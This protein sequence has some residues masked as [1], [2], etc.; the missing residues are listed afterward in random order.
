MDKGQGFSIATLPE[1][2]PPATGR[3]QRDGTSG[4]SG[5]VNGST[6][7]TL[8][9]PMRTRPAEGAETSDVSGEGYGSTGTTLNGPMRARP[10]EGAEIFTSISYNA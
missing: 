9:G 4:V 6:G 1:A 10:T 5:E 8:N 7:T 3:E 2:T